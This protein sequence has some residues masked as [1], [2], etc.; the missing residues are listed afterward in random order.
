MNEGVAASPK[1]PLR[2]WVVKLAWLGVP[3]VLLGEF[4]HLVFSWLRETLA[5]HFFHIVFGFGAGL[6]FLIYVIQDI[7]H[8]GRPEFSWRLHPKATRPPESPA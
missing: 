8:H 5:H 7:R 4:G 1:Q 2:S 6:I 3:L